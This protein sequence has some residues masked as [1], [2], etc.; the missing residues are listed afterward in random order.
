[1]PLS[2]DSKAIVA[3]NLTSALG[4]LVAS[5]KKDDEA[6]VIIQSLYDAIYARLFPKSSEVSEKFV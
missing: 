6:L 2:E 4:A 1:M 5:G 3:S